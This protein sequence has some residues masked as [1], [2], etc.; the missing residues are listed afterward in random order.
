MLIIHTL[1][2][3]YPLAYP[4]A[5]EYLLTLTYASSILFSLYDSDCVM[6]A[7]VWGKTFKRKAFEAISNVARI[8]LKVQVSKK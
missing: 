6:A 1:S 2:T 7:I 4:Q 5:E 3:P 8:Y